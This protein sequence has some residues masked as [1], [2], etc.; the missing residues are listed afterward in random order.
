M[1]CK[2]FILGGLIAALAVAFIFFLFLDGEQNRG[3][4]IGVAK[5]FLEAYYVSIDLEKTKELTSGLAGKQIDRQLGA[6][7][8]M[9]RVEKN[10]SQVSYRFLNERSLGEGKKAF[11]FELSIEPQGGKSF[12]RVVFLHLRR[13]DRDWR[14]HAFRE[15]QP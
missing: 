4:P 8:K 7:K 3:R 11:S 5:A 1:R 14:V 12:R 6:I 9:G 2:T 15:H 13:T 10:R